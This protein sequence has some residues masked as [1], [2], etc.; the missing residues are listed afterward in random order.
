MEL[1][2]RQLNQAHRSAVQA[3]L[4]SAGLQDVGHPMLLAILKS[5]DDSG[6]NGPCHAQRELAEL[7]HVSPAAV[8]NSLKS[9]ERGGYIHR[10][11]GLD[12]RRNRVFLTEAGR[13][14]VKACE[15]VFDT[16]SERMLAGF[17]PQ[18]L[19][20]L[21]SFRQRMLDNLQGSAPA[22]PK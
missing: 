3:Q 5:Y 7:L 17:T 13:Q 21:M 15:Q 11:P 19:T 8:T 22:T 10:E 18:E 20:Q 1:L 2:S 12:A 16:V 14:A 9:L 6:A 4:K